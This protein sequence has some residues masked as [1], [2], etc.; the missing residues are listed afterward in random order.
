[1][2]ASPRRIALPPDAVIEA[3]LAKAPFLAALA[4]PIRRAM[5]RSAHRRAYAAGSTVLQQGQHGHC[6]F[7]LVSGAVELTA[8][9]GD[10]PPVRL[11]TVITPGDFFGEG[12]VLGVT[13]RAAS[14]RAAEDTVLVEIDKAMIERLDKEARAAGG[15]GQVRSTLEAL[16]RVRAAQAFFAQHL[17]LAQLSPEARTLLAE[18][19]RL[20]L[21]RRGEPVLEEGSRAEDVV[22]I[23]SG[24]ARLDRAREGGRSVIGYFNPGDVF[25]PSNL[26]PA[27]VG[28]PAVWPGTLSAMLHL[29]VLQIDRR[30]FQQLDLTQRGYF[31]QAER[32]FQRRADLQREV[33]GAEGAQSTVLSALEAFETAGALEARSLLTINL[34]AC[35]RCGNCVRSCQA[36]HG[37]ARFVRKGKRITRREDVAVAG[38][39][40][41]ILLPS[42]CQHCA[43]PD[44]MVDCPT[45]AIHRKSTGEVSINPVT[46]IGCG[47][48]ARGCPWDNITM[49][50]SPERV[51]DVRTLL[52]NR[53][54][55][56][57]VTRGAYADVDFRRIASKCDL[58][59][60]YDTFNCVH[61]CPTG[62]ILR[63]DPATYYDE[64]RQFVSRPEEGV[65]AGRTAQAQGAD[66]GRIIGWV[67]LA[68]ALAGVVALGV[69]AGWRPESAAGRWLGLLALS[70]MAG[71][72]LLAARRRLNRL[73]RLR[74]RPPAGEALPRL[75]GWQRFLDRQLGSFK[76]WTR[77]HMG[78]G[79]LGVAAAI[80]HAGGRPGAPLTAA[81]LILTGLELITG[82]LGAGLLRWLPRRVSR[83][84]GDALLEDDLVAE[85]DALRRRR[86]DLLAEL[87]GATAQAD[88]HLAGGGAGLWTRLFGR[89]DGAA[90]RAEVEAAVAAALVDEARRP[91]LRALAIDQVRLR[92]ISACRL[93]YRLR[94][95]WLASHIA[96]TVALAVFIAVHVWAVRWLWGSLT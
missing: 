13:L 1:M 19:T 46:C 95:G 79:A 62:A 51:V 47:N 39:Y 22:V 9:G 84:E 54:N 87:D 15:P 16:A 57:G 58:C 52:T 49:V 94:R 29:E 50:P 24:L 85:A 23:K 91:T 86:R 61:N 28:Q 8:D 44:C 82:A 80:G 10:G 72:T 76:T 69:Q 38:R 59:E 65:G 17:Y 41:T 77:A 2:N 37:Q 48:C 40:E 92:E 5:A 78:L 70:S 34:N 21:F 30:V 67:L 6:L 74:R 11:D 53:I 64:L 56:A 36:R 75:S 33:Q 3:A 73:G 14:A 42:S 43:S 93:C 18:G 71:A 4:D 83:L 68:L 81:L 89:Y 45:G 27:G 25:L 63:V 20:R 90:R 55:E 35:V 88:A 12:A 96:I 32:D 66:R 31:M 7:V 26:T 60:G